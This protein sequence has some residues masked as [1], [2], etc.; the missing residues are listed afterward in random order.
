MLNGAYFFFAIV[1][2]VTALGFC[3]SVGRRLFVATQTLG[4]SD[5]ELPPN[6]AEYSAVARS[7]PNAEAYLALT[8]SQ[9]STK[10]SGLTNLI[11]EK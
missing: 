7:V 3:Q 6:R 9:C 1:F 5:P 2:L 8:D 4:E 11:R 10:Y